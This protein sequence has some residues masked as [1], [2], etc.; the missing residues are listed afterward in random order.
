MKK[1][2]LFFISL[3]FAGYLSAQEKVNYS[4]TEDNPEMHPK[5]NLNLELFQLDFSTAIIDASSSKG[6]CH[7]GSVDLIP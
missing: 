4:I 5:F 1:N 3:L 7:F 6:V 2:I